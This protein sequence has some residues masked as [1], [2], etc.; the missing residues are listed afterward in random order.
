MQFRNSSWLWC[1]VWVALGCA[2]RDAGFS[3]V[4]TTVQERVGHT[5]RYRDVEGPE[6]QAETDRIAAWLAKPL[7]ADAAVQIALLRNPRLQAAFSRLGIARAGLLGA[8]LPPNPELE[9]EFG[10]PEHDGSLH[11]SFAATESLTGLIALPLRRAQA[12]AELQRAQLRAAGDALDVAY[13]TRRAFY[14]CQ[15]TQQELGYVRDMAAAAALIR[16]LL[17]RLHGAGNVTEL[18][19]NEARAFE[20]NAQLMLEVAE[21]AAHDARAQLWQWLGGPLTPAT[22]QVQA[23]LPQVSAGLPPLAALEQRAVQRSLDLRSLDAEQ[24][25][26]ERRATAAQVQGVLPELR[27]GVY[28]ERDDGEWEWGPVAAL[29]LPLFN[30]GQGVVGAAEAARRGVEYEREAR[31][32]A[33]RAAVHALRARLTVAAERVRRYEEQLLP[34]RRQ[35]VEQ[36][37]RQ[38]NAMQIGVQQLLLSRSNELEAER[39]YVGALHGYWSLRAQLDQL[40]AGRLLD[41]MASARDTVQSG[42]AMPEAASAEG[43]H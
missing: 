21:L 23:Q 29:S 4:K 30:Q 9:A 38:Y 28:A 32:L 17:E 39:A 36:S 8:S 43:G 33:I 7:D 14:A 13:E 24:L 5:L 12:S 3:S 2:P 1:G 10:F 15:A 25:G 20:Q 16:E 34:L 27:A 26:L 37:L 42:A 22:L 35:I 11:M 6:D 31:T 41:G 18:E 19:L 40:L